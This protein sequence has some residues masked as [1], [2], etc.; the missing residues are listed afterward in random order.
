MCCVY[1]SE[2]RTFKIYSLSKFQIYTTVSLTIESP[3]CA[4]D[5]QDLLIHVNI[6]P[7][8]WPLWP[9][10][11]FSS[12]RLLAPGKHSLK[13]IWCLWSVWL[14][15]LLN[16]RS[17]GVG[18]S[19]WVLAISRAGFCSWLC[20]WLTRQPGE[21]I[22]SFTCH[23]LA[24][25]VGW[26]R[27]MNEVILGKIEIPFQRRRFSNSICSLWATWT[28]L[29]QCAINHISESLEGLLKFGVRDV[30][31]QKLPILMSMG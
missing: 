27:L 6:F 22:S 7:I 14:V 8:C 23:L 4:L 12:C 2:M 9:L 29:G 20:D 16:R 18:L 31:P 25:R 11:F 10:S 17:H 28:L 19:L 5:A 21:I 13:L 30:F 15:I 26:W 24:P 3:C 1:V